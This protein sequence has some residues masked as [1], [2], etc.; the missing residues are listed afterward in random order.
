MLNLVGA[1][2]V[3]EIVSTE[4]CHQ[5]VTAEE[6]GRLAA[7]VECKAV[8]D[9]QLLLEVIRY[10]LGT[11]SKANSSNFFDRQKGNHCIASFDGNVI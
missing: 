6:V 8:A 1:H 5:G 11:I 4:E 3:A 7:R 10:L 9:A 2:D